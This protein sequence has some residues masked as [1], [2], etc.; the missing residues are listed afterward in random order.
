M[1]YLAGE[2]TT[3]KLEGT[4]I[5]QVVSISGP[6]M[7]VA[8]VET[9]HLGSTHKEFRPSSIPEAG[10]V[11]ATIEYDPQQATHASLTSLMNSP[12]E[13]AWTIEFSDGSTYAFDGFL[14]AFSVTGAE[15][16]NNVTAEITIRINGDITITPVSP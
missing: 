9:T 12:Q 3:L 11:S 8:E 1:A 15:V 13:K 14:T 5:A 10:T 2:A 7:A 6:E 16:E 4:A